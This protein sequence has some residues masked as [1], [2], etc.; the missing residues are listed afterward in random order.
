MSRVYLVEDN[1]AIREAVSLY[2][3]VEGVEVVEFDGVRGVV[4]SMRLQRPDVCIIDVMLPD[5]DGFSLA[6]RIRE[7]DGKVG[8]VF[9]TAREAES[10]RIL[11][12][13][14]GADDYVVKPFS[15]RELVLRVKAL[16]RRMG[17]GGERGEAGEVEW[18][19]RRLRVDGELPM[20]VV[21]GREVRLTPA[22]W[23]I[24]RLLASSPGRV[25]TREQILGEALD[26]LYEGSARTVDTHIKNLRAKLG[27]SDWIETV[28]GIGYR[29]MGVRV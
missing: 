10:D 3:R 18:E 14:V 22:E 12:F 25:F 17:E 19:G 27:I 24:L 16:M 21:E 6:R 7:R 1:A 13:E 8:I 23:R 4:E 11:G 15:P 2:L 5:G 9:L 28:R 20:A 26:Y 29:M